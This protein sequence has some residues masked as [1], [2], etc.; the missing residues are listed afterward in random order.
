MRMEISFSKTGEMKYIS[1]LDL[2][3]LFQRASRRGSIP[4]T[5]TKG[6]SPHLKV[7][8]KRALKLGK[9]SKKEEASF[10]LD[11]HMSPAEFKEKLNQQLPQGIEV[12]NAEIV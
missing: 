1:H 2:M 9:E 5:V 10:S 4:V 6:F 11:E 7:S 3:R 8:V 12:I